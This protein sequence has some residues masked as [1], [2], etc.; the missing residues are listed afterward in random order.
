MIGKMFFGKE[1]PVRPHLTYEELRSRVLPGY[2]YMGT[3][4]AIKIGTGS[5]GALL[6]IKSFED[7]GMPAIMAAQA[8][9]VYTDDGPVLLA[10]VT[11][12]QISDDQKRSDQE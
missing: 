2:W 9:T 4:G 1:E 3:G 5:G 7:K 11:V 8:I 6:M 12:K 10:D